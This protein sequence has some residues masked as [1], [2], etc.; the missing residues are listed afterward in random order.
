MR[1]P[2]DS[3]P[4]KPTTPNYYPPSVPLSVYRELGAELQAVQTKLSVANQH[5]QRL[6]QENQELR[7][8]ITKV[9]KSFAYLQKLLDSSV[10]PDFPPTP[11]YSNPNPP[12]VI[13]RQQNF[14]RATKNPQHR[15]PQRQTQ[16]TPNP[17]YKHDYVEYSPPTVETH[18]P[19][20]ESVLVEEEE[21][22]YYQMGE[23]ES[24]L[25]GLNGLWLV[26]VIVLIML[27]GFSAGYFFIHPLFQQQNH[28]KET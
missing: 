23:S 15:P 14:A 4:K 8:E 7:Q 17:I 16:V 24:E 6:V 18:Y 3:I 2:I 22:R 1:T 28:Q 19:V 5:N 20:S 13:N 12:P 9:V 27:V 11:N 26:V 10:L 21:V 25:N